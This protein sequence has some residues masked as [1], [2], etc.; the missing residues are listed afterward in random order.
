MIAKV[1]NHKTNNAVIADHLRLTAAEQGMLALAVLDPGSKVL[2][3]N[4]GECQLLEYLSRHMQ[5]EICGVSGNMAEVRKARARFENADI[6]YTNQED[7]PWRENSFDAVFFRA[8]PQAKN[9]IKLR[10]TL[11]VLKPGGQLLLGVV[12]YPAPLWKASRFFTTDQE[13]FSLSLF[14]HKTG[15]HRL[16]AEIGFHPIAWHSSRF[17]C[18]I[19]V[20]RK[21]IARK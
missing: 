5:C 4:P 21:P 1:Q 2:D 11:R 15:W 10:E 9:D 16:L 20:G 19:A 12:G 7:I 3:M 17:T 14:M 13:R 6:L 18:K 8:E